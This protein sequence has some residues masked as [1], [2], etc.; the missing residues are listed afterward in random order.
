MGTWARARSSAGS[1]PPPTE[2][3]DR[4]SDVSGGNVLGRWQRTLRE[5][6]EATLQ[7]Y[8]DHTSRHQTGFH[9][10]RDTFDV[11]FQHRMR[12][13]YHQELIWGLEYRVSSGD[14]G[15]VSTIEFTPSRRTNHVVSGFLQDEV[16]L[17]DGR[18]RL[19]AG[20]KL[21]Y[22]DTSGVEVQPNARALFAPAAGHVVWGAIS[23]AV[24]TPSRVEQDL[25]ITAPIDLSTS[26]FA[27]VVGDGRFESESVIAYELG[28]RVQPVSRLFLDLTAFYND[29]ENLLSIQRGAAVRE[30]MPPNER[31]IF[32]FFLRNRLDGDVFGAEL[33]VDAELTDWWRVAA[34][35]SYLDM[36]LHREPGSNDDTTAQSTEGSSP[37]NQVSLRSRLDLPRHVDLDAI[38]RY[39]DNLAAQGVGSYL[40]LDVRVGWRPTPH[41]ELA[42]VGQDLLESHHA[43]FSGVGTGRA[44]ARRLRTD[45]VALLSHRLLCVALLAGLAMLLVRAPVSGAP[46]SEHAVKAA[47]LF[48]FANFV[49]WPTDAFPAPDAPLNICLLGADPFG[50]LLDATLADEK[51]EGRP[52]VARRLGSVRDVESC[53][54]VFVPAVEKRQLPALLATLDARPA[55]TVGE[56]EGFAREGGMIG[57]VLQNET[58]RFEVNATA[59][60]H[61]GLKMSAHLLNLARLV[62]T[63][64]TAR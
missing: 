42:V 9:E 24:R 56:S 2:I 41:L 62:E 23:R 35:Y 64:E 45:H 60:E 8:Y 39:V 36:D 16:T 33:A 12:L 15:A 21:E 44:P 52:L 28:Y 11:D 10:E 46:P 5:G 47:Y 13:P 1:Q 59:V 22:N 37:H 58:V 51:I 40:S 34:S 20:S 32:P 4:D 55:L 25:T 3:V 6:S 53:Q 19:I 27:Q 26:T 43:E 14:A 30:G 63:A 49:Q 38:L 17:A 48:N 50:P 18:L 57:F 7:L 31:T 29:Y 54:I 61:A